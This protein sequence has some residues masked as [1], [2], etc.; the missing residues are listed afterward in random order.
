MKKGRKTALRVLDSREEAEQWMK[1]NKGDYIEVGPGEDKKCQD[2]YCRVAA[3]CSYA[4][5][6]LKEMKQVG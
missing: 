4:Q 3:F 5:E 1:E 6:L 2:G